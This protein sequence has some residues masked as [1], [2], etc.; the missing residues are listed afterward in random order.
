M[1]NSL[2]VFHIQ[3]FSY[4][5]Y[6]HPLR[7]PTAEELAIVRDHLCDLNQPMIYYPW[8]HGTYDLTL[9]DAPQLWPVVT[10]GCSYVTYL[11]LILAYAE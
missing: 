8:S 5:G 10:E 11:P 2:I 9:K 1:P 6:T 3:A 7:L 4:A